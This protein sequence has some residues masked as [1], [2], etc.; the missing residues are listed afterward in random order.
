MKYAHTWRTLF[1]DNMI[2]FGNYMKC[3]QCHEI[4]AHWLQ[5]T[6][7][8]VSIKY[9]YSF[10]TFSCSVT[11]VYTNR[12]LVPGISTLQTGLVTL[13]ISFVLQILLCGEM[14]YWIPRDFSIPACLSSGEELKTAL[15][16]H[17]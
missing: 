3:S 1:H 13:Y 8:Y 14:V 17:P 9:V 2:L 11:F 4:T 7:S 16:F 5:C 6:S 12:A 15:C 10:L